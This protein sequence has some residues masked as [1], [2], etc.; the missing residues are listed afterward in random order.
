MYVYIAR[1]SSLRLIL[2]RAMTRKTTQSYYCLECPEAQ[3]GRPFKSRKTLSQHKKNS[4]SEDAYVACLLCSK[5]LKSKNLSRHRKL[6]HAKKE[7]ERGTCD[8][9]KKRMLKRS[10]V[11]HLQVNCPEEPEE[12]VLKCPYC[13]KVYKKK[14]NYALHLSQYKCTSQGYKINYNPVIKDDD[15]DDNVSLADTVPMSD[16]EEK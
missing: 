15:D 16:D 14:G 8:R 11:R 5:T 10:L 12:L 4:H 3:R 13:S 9:C 1:R 7:R 6:K 2:R